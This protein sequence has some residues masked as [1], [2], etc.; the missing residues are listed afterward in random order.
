MSIV[1]PVRCKKPAECCNEYKAAIVIDR[2]RELSD[3]MR[4]RLESKVI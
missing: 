2:F 4:L 3:F 1:D